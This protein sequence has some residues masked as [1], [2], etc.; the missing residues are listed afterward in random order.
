MRRIE[1]TFG[2]L[3]VLLIL[4]SGTINT[5]NSEQDDRSIISSMFP[6]KSFSLAGNLYVDEITQQSY[7]IEKI[8]HGSFVFPGNQEYLVIVRRPENES[9]HAEGFYQAYVAVFDKSTNRRLNETQLFCADEGYITLFSDGKVNYLFFAG[10]TTYQGWTTWNGG[11]WKAGKNWTK[12]W[13][14]DDAYWEDKYPRATSEGLTILRRKLL[15][16]ASGQVIP[17]YE[18]EHSYFLKWDPEK[19]CFGQ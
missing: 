11:L 8:I 9:S 6:G 7:Y 17:D 16:L 15:P 14:E 13:P 19:A 12:L 4:C 1:L 10:G 3:A 18:W 5:A 2:I